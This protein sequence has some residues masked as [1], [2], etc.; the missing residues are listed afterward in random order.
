[1]LTLFVSVEAKPGKSAKVEM[2]RLVDGYYQTLDVTARDEV[3]LQD[4]IRD[5][6]ACDLQSELVEISETW[7]PDWGGTDRDIRDHIGDFSKISVWYASG[8]AWFG[9]D[10][11]LDQEDSGINS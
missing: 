5:Y 4:L 3:D 2:N 11:D 7:P 1:M 8:R 6:L 9:P 10:L